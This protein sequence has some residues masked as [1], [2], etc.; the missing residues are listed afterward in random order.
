[1]LHQALQFV[2]VKSQASPYSFQALRGQSGRAFA[3]QQHTEGWKIVRQHAPFAV[4]YPPPWRDDRQVAN[5]ITF[6]LFEVK[7]MLAD[8]Y[9]PVS[10]QQPKEGQSNSVLE[11]SDLPARKSLVF[12]EPNFHY[13][14]P[15]GLKRQGRPSLLRKAILEA[16]HAGDALRAPAPYS[17]INSVR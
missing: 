12:R 4:Q 1:M 6:S 3:H 16:R 13:M 11:E 5:P 10:D 15:P 2:S 8:L 14:Q 7:M 9:P 17:S